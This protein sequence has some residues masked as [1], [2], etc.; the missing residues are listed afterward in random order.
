MKAY[1]NSEARKTF[2]TV[3]QEAE[4]DGAV[5]IRRRDG[6]VFAI[7]G[8]AKAQSLAFERPGCEGEN[9]RPSCNGAR[10][11]RSSTPLASALDSFKPNACFTASWPRPCRFP[12]R[13]TACRTFERSSAHPSPQ[14]ARLFRHPRQ[15]IRVGW[16]WAVFGTSSKLF[17]KQSCVCR[18]CFEVRA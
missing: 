3:L 12:I 4:R 5:E 14:A 17:L 6:A 7:V 13:T 15:R 10:R 18:R 1:T 11:T 9:A 16:S 8:R 2:A